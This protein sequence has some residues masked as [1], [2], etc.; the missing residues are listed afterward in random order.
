MSEEKTPTP[1]RAPWPDLIGLLG[2]GLLSYGSWRA[3]PPAGFIIPGIL[4]LAVAFLGAT[5]EAPRE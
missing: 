3:Y 4:L 5:R 2:L 1:R